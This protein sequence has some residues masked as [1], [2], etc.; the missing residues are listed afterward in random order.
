[1]DTIQVFSEIGKLKQVILH[2]P[3]NELRNIV[4]DLMVD[5]LFDEVPF[6]KGAVAEHDEFARIL[7]A[8]GAEIFYIE[9]M[10]AEALDDHAV[11]ESFVDE[12]IA[13]TRVKSPE[14]LVR[15]KDFL[16]GLPS[17]SELVLQAM[18]GIRRSDFPKPSFSS[19]VDFVDTDYPFV[20]DPMPNLYFTRDPFA[21]VG[22]GVS[23]NHMWSHVRGR[24][25][26]FGKYIFE[27]HP[28]FRGTTV[29]MYYDRDIPFH[30]EGGDQLVL[31]D[32]V[33]AI[34]LSQRTEPR[35]AEIF[36][37]KVLAG[38]DGFETILA[39]KFPAKRA[40]M[41]LDTVFTMVDRD[42]FTIHP[43]IEQHLQVIAVTR[44][45]SGLRFERQDDDL[46]SILRRY[47]GV[48]QVQ[49]LPCGKGDSIDAPSEQW[50]DG[51]NTFAIGPREL[52][53][54][55]RNVVTNEALEEAGVKL[56]IMP[57]AELSRGRGGP[58]CMTM[59]LVREPL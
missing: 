40:F 56:H 15:L 25:T 52:I 11:R 16:L 20:T 26:L 37:E 2:R 28:R 19:L 35:A 22:S 1:M 55:D 13:E 4:P 59:P 43:E 39:F 30:I 51:S 36:A 33:L 12:F 38:E 41:H 57:S 47:L 58:R 42:L 24:E 21:M 49:L 45:K 34:G 6:L 48:D 8:N 29:P 32:K 54:Y 46:E 23:L 44:S 10:A 14:E 9:D 17:A 53:V 50:S 31:S 3:G 27:H 5:F 7:R 18:S